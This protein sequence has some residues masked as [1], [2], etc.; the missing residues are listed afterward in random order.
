M[1]QEGEC[2]RGSRKQDAKLR[3][4]HDDEDRRPALSPRSRTATHTLIP[5]VVDSASRSSGSQKKK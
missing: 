2:I 3:H 4:P 1:V 5:T